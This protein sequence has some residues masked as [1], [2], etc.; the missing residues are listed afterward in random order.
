[1]K[2]KGATDGSLTTFTTILKG[3]TF[4]FWTTTLLT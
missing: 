3:W 2:E 1:M 4:S